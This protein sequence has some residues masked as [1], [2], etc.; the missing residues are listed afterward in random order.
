[1]S[2]EDLFLD[3]M[4]P[5]ATGHRMIGEALAKLLKER[6]WTEGRSL[7]EEGTGAPRPDY[8]DPFLASQDTSGPDVVPPAEDQQHAFRIE[9]TL[10]LSDLPSGG[11]IQ[12]EVVPPGTSP[13]V[14]NSIQLQE[15]G[16]FVLPVKQEGEVIIR[17][18]VDTEGDGPDADDARHVFKDNTITITETPVTGVTIDLDEGQLTIDG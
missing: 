3:K 17:V 12:I 7:W 2:K 16:K 18:Y 5:T 13:T 6:G 15:P 11:R 1:L 8:D 9:G 14:I 4:H 10:T